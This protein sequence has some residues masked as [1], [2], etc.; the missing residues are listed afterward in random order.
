MRLRGTEKLA[1]TVQRMGVV[2][3]L[4]Q[5][6]DGVIE[7][8]AHV[9]GFSGVAVPVK[10]TQIDIVECLTDNRLRDGAGDFSVF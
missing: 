5:R 6:A 1:Q 3:R 7:A 9:T 8:A 2:G 4:A 10:R